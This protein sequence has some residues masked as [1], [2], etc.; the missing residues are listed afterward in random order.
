MIYGTSYI[1]CKEQHK[2]NEGRCFTGWLYVM[3]ML[4][5]QGMTL[6]LLFMFLF[7]AAFI[8]ASSATV[9]HSY[10]VTTDILQKK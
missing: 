1:I 7:S 5:F 8:V 2:L 6:A 10:G 9:L 3:Y 4:L